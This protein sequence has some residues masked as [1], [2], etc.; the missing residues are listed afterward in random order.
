MCGT[1]CEGFA[2]PP[3][4]LLS[5]ITLDLLQS[6]RMFGGVDTPAARI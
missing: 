2:I 5:N 4:K 1:D 6:M 3:F